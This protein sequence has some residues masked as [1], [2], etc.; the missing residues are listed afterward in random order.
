VQAWYHGAFEREMGAT[1]RDFRRCLPEAFEPF[2]TSFDPA[3]DPAAP[4]APS[5]EQVASVALGT[6][7]ARVAWRQLAPRSIGLLA[8]LPRLHVRFDF[9]GV[10]ETE[11]QK[12]MKRFDLVMLRGGG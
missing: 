10:D 6:G 5:A 4:V 7:T 11:R 2:V 8:S 12:V 9:G 1:A 3:A